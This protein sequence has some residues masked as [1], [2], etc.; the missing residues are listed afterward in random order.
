MRLIA[1]LPSAT[2]D[3]LSAS[4]G[5]DN[6]YHNFRWLNKQAKIKY[7]N[8][9]K[10]INASSPN[11]LTTLPSSRS[12]SP[13]QV[14]AASKSF[15][16]NFTR[17]NPARTRAAVQVTFELEAFAY[18]SGPLFDGGTDDDQLRAPMRGCDVNLCMINDASSS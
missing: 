16:P 4:T 9:H 11:S 2:C 5:H 17:V 1:S 8:N 10:Q 7:G 15:A 13:S 3:G 18:D 14:L 12:R 6:G